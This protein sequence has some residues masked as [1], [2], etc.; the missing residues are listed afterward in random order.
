MA[1]SCAS[2]VVKFLLFA[3]NIIFWLTGAILLV[4]GIW[5]LDSHSKAMQYLHIANLNYGLVQAAAI[6]L[7]IVGTVV[8]IIGLLGCCG[9]MKE[10]QSLLSAFSGFL[11]FLLIL[12]VIAV[13]LAGSLHSQIIRN[14]SKE[15]NQSMVHE[16]DQYGHKLETEAWNF[17]QIEFKCCGISDDGIADWSYTSWYTNNNTANAAVPASCCAKLVN[18]HNF[19]NPIPVDPDTCYGA[20]ANKTWP[21]RNEEVYVK[22]CEVKLNDWFTD[23]LTVLIGVTVAIIIIQVIIVIMACVLKKSIKNSYEHI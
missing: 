6:T 19:T 15:M 12:Q 23:S 3:M 21:K 9:V 14:L 7:I 22:G 13:I 5:I 16:Y 4:I 2:K 1:L 18:K 20:A 8:F 11:I 10:N 17:V